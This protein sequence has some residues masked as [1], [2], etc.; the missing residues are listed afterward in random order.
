MDDSS[1]S[2]EELQDSWD[3]IFIKTRLEKINGREELGTR[4]RFWRVEK[5]RDLNVHYDPG[6][7][8]N[9][10]ALILKPT[11]LLPLTIPL[12]LCPCF[13]MHENVK[14]NTMR[15]IVLC[16]FLTQWTSGL[17]DLL[18]TLIQAIIE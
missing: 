5:P 14:V 10:T 15:N 16:V 4:L 1:L 3:K 18:F 17:L 6:L 2:R 7:D 12:A 9:D 11:L 8:S 13:H